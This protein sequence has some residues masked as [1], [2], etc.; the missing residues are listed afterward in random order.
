MTSP[1]RTS[2]RPENA[3]ARR[4][5]SH[6]G[7]I[8]AEP[9]DV[10]TLSYDVAAETGTVRQPLIERIA[11]ESVWFQSVTGYQPGAVTLS[12]PELEW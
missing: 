8:W 5:R 2:T 3:C 12:L 11:G 10:L 9:N 6:G 4:R 7:L 1:S